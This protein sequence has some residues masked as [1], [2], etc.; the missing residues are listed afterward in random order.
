MSYAA[1]IATALATP[2]GHLSLGRGGFTQHFG[3]ARLSGYDCEAIK[4]E[5]LAP[6]LLVIDSRT[7]PFELAAILAVCGPV[8]AVNQDTSPHPWHGFAYTPLSFVAAAHRRAGAEVVD[9]PDLPEAD[10]WVDAHPPGPM[11]DILQDWFQHVRRCGDS[12]G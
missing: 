4:A 7:I 11:A 8:V 12:H 3:T 5:A 2:G 6:G 9:I 10:R 1:E